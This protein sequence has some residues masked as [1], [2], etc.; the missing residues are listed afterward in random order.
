M[1]GLHDSARSLDA[2]C[3]DI[4]ERY[5]ASLEQ[6][7]PVIRE[8]LAELASSAASPAFEAMRTAFAELADSIRAH[9]AKEENLLF[10]ALEALSQAERAGRSRPPLPFAT[11]LHPIRLMEAEHARI[12]HALE[13]LRE[14]ARGVPQS[15][16]STPAW[17]RCMA[18]LSRLET[19]LREDHRIENEVLFPS[20][21]ELERRVL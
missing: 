9:L 4:V 1:D 21:L 2:M 12:E 19:E 16:T 20:A 6:S 18:G 8:E 3:G 7:L 13:Q 17:R 15:G 14:I 10:P 11:V 5:H